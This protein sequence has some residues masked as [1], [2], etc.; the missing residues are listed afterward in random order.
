MSLSIG[1][2]Q[3]VAY[4]ILLGLN[5][6]N[7]LL[8]RTRKTTARLTAIRYFVPIGNL[9]RNSQS[10]LADLLYV[11]MYFQPY[12]VVIRRKIIYLRIR[13][14]KGVVPTG[15]LRGETDGF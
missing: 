4:S 10:K 9:H 12:R 11:K 14:A 15:S 8:V 6:A 7:N 3:F 1:E 13:T 2:I 5:D